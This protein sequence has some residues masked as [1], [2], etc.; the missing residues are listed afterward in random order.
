MTRGPAASTSP[1][2]LLEIQ[3]LRG[4]PRPTESEPLGVGPETCMLINLPC[5]FDNR[6]MSENYSF[7]QLKTEGQ[8]N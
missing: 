7:N 5:D 1:G 2:S 6:I 4:H 8:R 3:V